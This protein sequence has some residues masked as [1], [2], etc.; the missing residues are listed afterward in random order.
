M[1]PVS[2]P[3]P[4]LTRRE[5]DSS[6]PGEPLAVLTDEG[7][8]ERTGTRIAFTERT[9]GSS[10]GPFASLSLAPNA[11]DDPSAVEADIA[12][13]ADALGF[14]SAPIV[15]PK[16]VHGTH[17]VT[18]GSADAAA[19]SAACDEVAEGADGVVVAAP[20]VA[21][22]LCFADCLP[23]V[24]VAPSGAFAV[25]HAGWRGA[26]AG[27]ASK[28]ARALAAAEAASG[29]ASCP[30]EAAAQMSAYIGPYIHSECFEC[31]PE[32]HGRFAAA[33]GAGCTPD[34]SHVDLGAAVRA[35]LEGVGVAS[36]RIVDAGLCTACNPSRFFSY[37]ASGGTCGRHG[38]FAASEGR[39]P[40]WA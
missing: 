17:L 18:V 11:S 33:Y 1:S 16:Q 22:L 21:A 28:A 24:L 5:L 29:A 26:V 3:L 30:E 6:C 38:A 15:R 2:L 7:L 40:S 13:L 27:I 20:G 36:E 9:G 25:V 10:A 32:V 31:G 4:C 35:D 14:P 39:A 23:L 34:G 8:F 37:R 12:R 19:V